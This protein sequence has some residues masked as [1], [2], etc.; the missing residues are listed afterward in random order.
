MQAPVAGTP[1]GEDDEMTERMMIREP[2]RS[3]PVTG[4]FDVIVVGGGIAGVAAAVAAARRSA[5]VCLVERYCALGGLATLGNV[6]LWLPIC[7]GRGRQVVG[8]LGAELLHLS[9]ADL[10]ADVPSA[11]F[12]RV[13]EC[14]TRGGSVK[15]RAASRCFAGFNPSSYMLALEK[16]AVEAGVD[17][18]Y[19]SRVCAVRR[20]GGRISHV[21]VENKSGRSAL[22]AGTVVDASGDADVCHLAGEKTLSLDSNTL[23][24]WFYT[25]RDGTLTL[26]QHS[27]PY[28]PVGDRTNAEGPFFRGDDA[29]DVTA[30]VLQTRELAR[31]WLADMRQ[32][33]PAE[34]IHLLMPAAVA[35]LRMTRRLVAEF[36]LA[37]DHVHQWFEDAVGLTGDWRKPGPVFAIPFRCLRAPRNRNLLAAGRCVSA[38]TSAWDVLRAI[39]PCAVTGEAAGTAAAMAAADTAGDVS[40]L[41]IGALQA[42]LGKQGVLL[43]PNL[44]AASGETR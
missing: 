6:T 15:E 5:R 28:S 41:D 13:P 2:A 35:C 10:R 12:Q 21:I 31:A 14:W 37:Q 40:A 34:D 11:R 43:D 17:L 24:G 38:D 23:A 1:A 8:G 7:D 33:H 29:R 20:R 39:P 18:L 22:A 32:R 25:L 3:V 27:R 19:D 42:Q 44:V 26:R 4:S 36:S 16:W 30:Q 9:V